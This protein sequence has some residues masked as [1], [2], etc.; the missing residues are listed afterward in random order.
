MRCSFADIHYYFAAPTPKPLLH[1]FDKSSYLYLYHNGTQRKTRIEV[2][3]N[4]GTP[5]QDAF[6]GG[7]FAAGWTRLVE[8]DIY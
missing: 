2:A 3:N 7:K 4:P 6:N 5:D 8:A 1:R